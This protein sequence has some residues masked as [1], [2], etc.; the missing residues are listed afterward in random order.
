MQSRFY[1][2]N[3]APN[4]N[5]DSGQQTRVLAVSEGIVDRLDGSDHFL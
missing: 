1:K 4:D 2:G 3:E 5:I